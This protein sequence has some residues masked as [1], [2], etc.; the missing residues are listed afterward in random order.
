VSGSTFEAETAARLASVEAQLVELQARV[1]EL[2][3]PKK[4][5]LDAGTTPVTGALQQCSMPTSPMDSHGDV[6]RGTEFSARGEHQA[7]TALAMRPCDQTPQAKAELD[8]VRIIPANFHHVAMYYCLHPDCPIRHK[9]CWMA[10]SLCMV[11][12]QTACALALSL[13]AVNT[14]CQNTKECHLAGQFCHP[15]FSRCLQCGDYVESYSG[16]DNSTEYCQTHSGGHQWACQGCRHPEEFGHGWDPTRFRDVKAV[17]IGNLAWYDHASLLLAFFIIALDVSSELRESK[18]RQIA[19]RQ[20]YSAL[21]ARWSVWRFGWFLLTALRQFALLPIVIRTAALLVFRGARALDIFFNTLAVVFM[22]NVDDAA[23]DNL[24]TDS[25]KE[26]VEE[27]GHVVIKKSV[28]R[29]LDVHRLLSIVLVTSGGM[30]SFF[31]LT[32]VNCW[33]YLAL[34]LTGA[35]GVWV[36]DS[37]AEQQQLSLFHVCS[38]VLLPFVVGA[39]VY[40]ALAS[41]AQDYPG[42]AT[43]FWV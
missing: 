34:L 20:H 37:T 11:A 1:A 30:A 28:M 21:R 23:Y 14:S 26:E 16:T 2:D 41:F 43:S 27:F 33:P 22:L 18:L 42:T 25:V 38:D 9:S 3:V 31:F 32:R 17:I 29:R 4:S 36:T 19:E 7:A 13:E 24:L 10:S 5:E 40:F 6:D 39:G 8:E 12:V 15:D 35:V